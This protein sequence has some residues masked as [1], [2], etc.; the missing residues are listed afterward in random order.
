VQCPSRC[1]ADEDASKV[2]FLISTGRNILL[3]PSCES[4]ISLGLTRQGFLYSAESGLYPIKVCARLSW[5]VESKAESRVLACLI[6][7]GRR[8]CTRAGF[9]S[10]LFPIEL[11]SGT[12]GG[13]DAICIFV[14]KKSPIRVRDCVK[15]WSENYFAGHALESWLDPHLLFV[16]QITLRVGVLYGSVCFSL[17]LWSFGLLLWDSFVWILSPDIIIFTAAIN[18]LAVRNLQHCYLTCLIYAGSILYT[19]VSIFLADY[20]RFIY[21][22]DCAIRAVIGF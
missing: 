3:Y 11:G 13:G 15:A 6:Y 7:Q 14:L 1:Q 12:L 18:V 8:P 10:C 22:L 21:T 16:V 17:S 5:L 19:W 9:L 4:C 2:F 20:L